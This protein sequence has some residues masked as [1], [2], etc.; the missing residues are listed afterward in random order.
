[1]VEQLQLLVRLQVVDKVL[2]DLQSE[3]DAIPGRLAE[4]N[5][6][7]ERLDAVLAK[8][9]AELDEVIKRRKALEGENETIRTRLRKA[10]NRLMGSKSQKEYRAAS[11]EIDEGKDALKS[12]DDALIELMERQE[13]LEAS[14]GKAEAE[15]NEF[16]AGAKEER[17]KLEARNKEAD[18]EIKRLSKDRTGLCQGIE[19]KL[20]DQ[21]DF[22]RNR[23]QGLALAGVSQGTCLVCRMQ[24]PPQQF[25]ELQRG[26]K[27]MICPS[28]SRIIYWA[29]SE[30]FEGGNGSEGGQ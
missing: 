4:M 22:I 12:N 10:E 3:C 2:F 26:D 14:K 8:V 5:L 13:A 11:A 25:N 28:C 17:A 20:M 16:Q 21:Y 1:L 15:L 9:Q 7:E 23:R 18:A 29:D 19:R 6:E 30:D 24:L 27:L